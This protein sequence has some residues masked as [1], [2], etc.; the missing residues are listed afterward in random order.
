MPRDGVARLLFG[1]GVLPRGNPFTERARF[2]L[3]GVVVSNAIG[4]AGWRGPYLDR[5]P[6]DPWGR[7]YLALLDAG[8]RAPRAVFSAGPN[9]LVDTKPGAPALAGDDVGVMIAGS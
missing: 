8:A 9:G 7:A 4:A 2:P 5:V 3:S 6:I 1:P